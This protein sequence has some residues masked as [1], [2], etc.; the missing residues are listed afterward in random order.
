MFYSVVCPPCYP[1]RVTPL[2]R[3]PRGSARRSSMAHHRYPHELVQSVC[4]FGGY[5]VVCPVVRLAT[6]TRGLRRDSPSV[7]RSTAVGAW[8]KQKTEHTFVLAVCVCGWVCVLGLC[9]AT[10]SRCRLASATLVA[11]LSDLVALVTATLSL[12][13][14]TVYLFPATLSLASAT[15]LGSAGRLLPVPYTHLRA[16]E[17]ALDLV[18]RLLL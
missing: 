12:A 4:A 2:G 17:T 3:D 16:H 13:S 6:G 1:C 18:C 10:V 5:P 15:V 7:T 8:L 9:L 14:A 11:C